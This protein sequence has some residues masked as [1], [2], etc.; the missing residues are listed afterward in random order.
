METIEIISIDDGQ[1]GFLPAQQSGELL[2]EKESSKA[3]S[4][5]KDVGEMILYR[6]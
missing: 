6:S 1:P 4:Q 2:V 5:G 3:A